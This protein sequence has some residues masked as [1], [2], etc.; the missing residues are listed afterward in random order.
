MKNNIVF[1]KLKIIVFLLSFFIT[2]FSYAQANYCKI[3]GKF[4]DK[5]IEDTVYLFKGNKP[6]SNLG[7][8]EII[9]SSAIHNGIFSFKIPISYTDFYSI[10]SKNLEKGFR[11]ICSPGAN[12][13]ITCDTLNFYHP[14]ITS[15]KE[16]AIIRNAIAG[17]DPLILKMNSYADSGSYALK[18][19]DSSQSNKYDSLNHFWDEE[20]QR[21]NISFIKTNPNCLTSLDM[22]NKYYNLFS[23]DSVRLYLNNL[24]K[25]LQKNPLAKEIY[26]KKFIRGTELT[27]I[28][29]FY[30]LEFFDTLNKPFN[31]NSFYD[32]LVLIDF[33]ASWCKPCIANFPL[34]KRIEEKYRDKNFAI[35]GVSLD[36]NLKRWKNEIRRS[37]LMWKNISDFKGAD[38]L[39]AKYLNIT[40]IPRYVLI[41]KD[42]FIIND[43]IKKEEI[44]KTIISNL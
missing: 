17:R 40:T 16:N 11:I 43:D 3:N 44:E 14:A 13:K 28:T 39:G 31:F 1:K 21:Y 6:Y 35:I 37:G 42:G 33:W 4:S 22:F 19:K 32:K 2:Q 15:S 24:P 5:N 29:K 34:L 36:D 26:Y 20:I 30:D 9:A 41:G 23:E 18:C 25:S 10:K 8:V 27:K 7:D 12:M 38:G